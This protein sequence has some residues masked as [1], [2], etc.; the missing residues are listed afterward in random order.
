MKSHKT[1]Q[2]P[3]RDAFKLI[4]KFNSQYEMGVEPFIALVNRIKM[5][6]TNSRVLLDLIIAE[7]IEG[8]AEKSIRFLSIQSCSDLFK[9]LRINFGT[10]GFLETYRTK[11]SQIVQ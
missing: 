11:L 9:S 10:T 7:K 5:Q 1:I 3:L 2:S 6:C 4:K 8:E